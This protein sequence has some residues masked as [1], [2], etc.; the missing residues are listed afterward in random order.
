MRAQFVLIG[1]AI[2][3]LVAGCGSD[4][5]DEQPTPTR[6]AT[7]AAATA[8]RTGVPATP[9]ATAVVAP[10]RTATSAP[11]NTTAPSTH[12]STEAPTATPTEPPTASATPSSTATATVTAT[13][14]PRAVARRIT[15]EADLISGPLA[16][17]RVDDYLLANDVARFIIQDAPQ[18]DL[19]SVGAFGG[20]LI[21][22]ELIGHPGL[23][24]FLEIQPAVQIE[25][26]INAQSVE[27]VNDGADGQAAVI[28]SCGPDDV[29]DFVN[30]STIIEDIGGLQFP[31]VADDQDYD[32]EGCTEYS[33]EV[34][35][36]YVKMVT[37][38]MNDAD[39]DLGLFVGD[40]INA[41]G[42]V[43]QWTS[44]GAGIGEALTGIHGVLSYIGFGEATGV[45]YSHVTV[46]VP[47][48]PIPGSSFFTAAGVSYVMQSNTVINVILG[49]PPTFLVPAHGSNSYTRYFG[50]GDGSGA[51]GIDI[52]NEVK[53]LTSGTVR[54]C[55]LIGDQP[56]TAARVSIGP[57]TDGAIAS[58]A[59]T[60]VTDDD[61]CYSGT[62]APGEYGVVAARGG[63]PYE[64]GATTPL[65]HPITV[66][67][68]E[69][70]EQD[71]ALPATGRVHVA[72][73]DEQNAAVPARIGVVGFDPSPEI[74]LGGTGL[75]ND[76]VEALPFGYAHIGYTDSN[77]VA[78]FDLEPGTYQ[79]I[80]SRGVEYSSF[81]QEIT[82]GADATTP[83]Q[84]R[85]AR[86]VDTAGFISSDYHVH[87]IASADS[88]VPDVNRVKQYAGEGVDNII[89][90]D[91]HAHTDLTPT[92]TARGF[93]PFV[94][95]TIGEEIT[96]WDYGH[97]NAYPLLIDP[98]RASG[99]S[100][101]WAGAAE[102][103]HDFKS[104][105]AFSATPQEI[106]ALAVEGPLSTPD[107]VIQINHIDSF[108]DPLRIDT[109]LV[110]PQSFISAADKLRY[111]IDPDS[112][113][114]F[115][116]YEALEVWNG[117][118]RGKQSEFLDLRLGIWFNH[119][120]QGLITTAIAD[121]DS[122]EFLPLSAAGARTWTA[123]PTDDPAAIDPADAARAVRAGRA[124]GGQGVYVQTRLRA[125]DGSNGVADLTLGGS[126]QVTSSN[127]SVTL[128]INAQAPI[129]APF[130][131][132]EIYANA[133]TVVA[134][135]RD[136]VPTLYGAEP[137]L[138]LVAGP[139]TRENVF[140]SIPG[141]ERWSAALTVP[142]ENLARDTWF[143]VI[144]KGTDGVSQPMFP[145]MSGDIPAAS[146]QTLADLLDGNLNE[147]GVLALGHTNAL[148]ADVDG[149]AGFQAP[150][151][152]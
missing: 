141:A 145:V 19:Y 148:Y 78:E 45:D 13:T 44:A 59:T 10:T 21:D 34:G 106:E 150:L 15:D 3:T 43:E 131:R 12:T 57:V 94:T 47:G 33:L 29:L 54:G 83:V 55:V 96:T 8:T 138:V 11:T 36:P 67:A 152:P 50:V 88:R 84:A 116:P 132:V 90:T 31:A 64:G 65:V 48:S 126:T 147:G 82:V 63:V 128:E 115:H 71:I 4:D 22:V 110:P 79:L 137:T 87:G 135:T 86:V 100:T 112:G 61:G 114:L 69:T 72:V 1:L 85:I 7:A 39:T 109:A 74:R 146:N 38:I 118:S 127:A 98:T 70:T 51:N 129:W 76:P 142:F 101:D 42:E 91:H 30:P 5:D 120:N 136:G 20:N 46:P 89:M 99:G 105:G 25:T 14:P 60:F 17:G 40:Y 16:D 103:G 26:V 102:A 92:I 123:S 122:H 97:F 41:A 62:L 77:G 111:R 81:S 32:V 104:L 113:N 27:I 37:T 80:A 56:G 75:F 125:G 68:G 117:A 139:L 28:R 121:T 95:S 108:Y 66:S 73:T 24:N 149:V 49:A 144:V 130:D 93:T 6:T 107:T 58:V 133:T 35:K 119:L 18:R 140:P 124:V 143:V 151:Q 2:A 9:T 134:R 53:G 52:E 23:D